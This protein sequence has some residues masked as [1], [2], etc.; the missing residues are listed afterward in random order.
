[1]E[2]LHNLAVWRRR[3]QGL[4]RMG[5]TPIRSRLSN[6]SSIPYGVRALFGVRDGSEVLGTGDWPC[7][8]STNPMLFRL[9]CEEW[10][11]FGAFLELP[12]QEPPPC[13]L[14][15]AVVGKSCTNVTSPT[16]RRGFQLA[17]RVAPGRV[18]AEVFRSMQPFS[19]FPP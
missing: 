8:V 19:R 15:P 6:R 18:P 12:G 14:R 13:W 16:T 1:M 4:G 3:R 7:L 9:T 11:L 5:L 17:I 10:V 2:W